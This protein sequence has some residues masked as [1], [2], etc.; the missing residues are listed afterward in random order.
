MH[1]LA[2]AVQQFSLPL[3]LW[4]YR[5]VQPGPREAHDF[6]SS[7]QIQRRH[8]GT[9]SYTVQLNTRIRRDEERK[10]RRRKNG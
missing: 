9:E 5:K 7:V 6:D 3:S 2:A 1:E 8:D 4:T 10:E